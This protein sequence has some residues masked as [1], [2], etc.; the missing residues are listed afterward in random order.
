[1]RLQI[2]SMSK[3]W[4]GFSL[5]CNETPLLGVFRYTSLLTAAQTRAITFINTPFFGVF[6]YGE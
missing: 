1:M 5:L 4:L 6:C 2:R 3:R